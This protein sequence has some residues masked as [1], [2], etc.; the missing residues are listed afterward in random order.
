MFTK[1]SRE[2]KG[3]DF[4]H[5]LLYTPHVFGRSVYG[6]MYSHESGGWIFIKALAHTSQVAKIRGV[7]RTKI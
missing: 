4:R 3:N 6:F 5:Y 1:G 2:K 7:R